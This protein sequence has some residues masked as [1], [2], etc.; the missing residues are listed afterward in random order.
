MTEVEPVLVTGSAGAGANW[1]RSVRA[2]GHRNFRAFFTGGLISSIG[3]NMQVAALAWVV[4]HQTG[5]ATRTTAIAFI[6]II[7]ML[8]LGPAAGVLADRFERRRILMLTSALNLSQAAVLWL[9]WVA[10]DGNRYWLL[11][12]LSAIGGIFTALQTP[13]WQALPAQLVPRSDLPNAITLNTTQFNIARALGPLCA[14]VMIE[15]WSAGGAFLLNALSY[16]AVIIALI[17]MGPVRGRVSTHDAS[18]GTIR[19]WL[20][21]VDYIRA[22][23]ALRVVIGVHMVFAFVV[24]PVVYLIPKLSISVLHV[25]AASYGVLLGVFGIG[26]IAAAVVLNVHEDS[27]RRSLALGFGLGCGAL[28]LLGL[29]ATNHYSWGIVAMIGLGVTYLVVVSINHGTIQTMTDDDHRGRVTSVWLMTFG[30]FMP[31]GSIVQGVLADRIGVRSVLAGDGAIL[32]A[33]LAWV[34]ARKLLTTLDG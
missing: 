30:L 6:G 20:G 19:N 26:A 9:A 5:S 15:R 23:P 22:R 27:I 16:A 4:Q 33:L 1:H 18:V 25:G 17:V 13:A 28:S 29:A 24:P 8:I 12:T 7:P 14:G 10:G 34:S 2:L 32:V 3:T 31:V 21:G 11:F